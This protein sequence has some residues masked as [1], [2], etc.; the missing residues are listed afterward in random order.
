VKLKPPT[1]LRGRKARSLVAATVAI[2]GFSA[3]AVAQTTTVAHADPTETLVA[4]GSDTIQ[5]VYNQFSLDLTGNA[6]GSYDAVNPVTQT[7]G[8]N[9][10]YAD[11]SGHTNCSFTR[12][13]GSGAG[14]S[15]LRESINPGTSIGPLTGA[16][17]DQ[18][19]C[20]D[21]GRSSSSVTDDGHQSNT[22][23]IVFVPFGVDAVAGATGSSTAG[24]AYSYLGQTITPQ[25]TFITHA[26][27]FSFVDLVN[28][29]KNCSQITEDGVV[30][31]PTVTTSGAGGGTAA[32]PTPIHLYIPQA[33]S[34]TAKF[35]IKV[36]SNGGG[37]LGTCVHNTIDPAA[38][39]PAVNAGA[40]GLI[41]EEH[42][43]TAM[44][45]DPNGFGPFSIAQWIAQSNSTSNGGTLNTND[46]RHTAIVQS[47][48]GCTSVTFGSPATGTCSTT[49]TATGANTATKGGTLNTSFPIT[50][51]VYSVVSFARVSS[52]TDPLDSFLNAG[53]IQ[54]TLCNDVGTIT[55]FGFAVAPDCGNVTTANRSLD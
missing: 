31:D 43:G 20:V 6:L 11:G 25:A 33:S 44:V 13:N 4:V 19:G 23:P 34:C 39:L 27:D 1:L 54:D 26:S 46:R 41:V 28:L 55:S 32:N 38:S 45:A 37:A 42:N 7:A 5:D 15:A 40:A 50:R 36:L 30:Y 16:A 24:A 3:L 18:P 8:D 9:I 22:G 12:P 47:L 49:P 10:S 2:L 53:S 51:E 35:W 48:K 52:G 29:F 17:L 14:L 21:I